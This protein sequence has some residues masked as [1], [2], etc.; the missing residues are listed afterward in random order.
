M[1]EYGCPHC[2]RRA[3]DAAAVLPVMIE[4]MCKT[5]GKVEVVPR[6]ATTTVPAHRTYECST[7]H[8]TQHIE[9]PMN[10]RSY[11]VTCG[12]QTLVIV[13][14]VGA[15]EAPGPRS[16]RRTGMDRRPV[17]AHVHARDD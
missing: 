3:F 8:R 9:R 17:E 10:E 2:G 16:G 5:H 4:W 15:I 11:C 1:I 12:T 13:A 7:C 14:E 6:H